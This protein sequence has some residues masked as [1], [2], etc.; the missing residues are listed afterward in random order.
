MDVA[1]NKNPYNEWNNAK[2]S[3]DYRSKQTQIS[4]YVKQQLSESRYLYSTNRVNPGANYVTRKNI[5]SSTPQAPHLLGKEDMW[6]WQRWAEINTSTGIDS[7]L[8]SDLLEEPSEGIPGT[9][10]YD[11]G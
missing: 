11:P 3:A 9:D 6:G 2:Q 5:S 8:A 10:S 4:S 7:T 1:V